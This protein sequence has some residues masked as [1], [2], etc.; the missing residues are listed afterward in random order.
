MVKKIPCFRQVVSWKVLVPCIL[1][2]CTTTC[3]NSLDA[4]CAGG[5]TPTDIST[6]LADAEA[7]HDAAKA[8]L[9]AHKFVAIEAM[10]SV[11]RSPAVNDRPAVQDD[12]NAFDASAAEADAALESPGFLRTSAADAEAALE[13][14]GIDGTS[15]ADAEAASKTD[16]LDTTPAAVA[17]AGPFVKYAADAASTAHNGPPQQSDNGF[18]SAEGAEVDPELRTYQDCAPLQ[19]ERISTEDTAHAPVKDAISSTHDKELPCKT[20]GRA[21]V[22]PSNM[23]NLG[24]VRGVQKQQQ[25]AKSEAY[26]AEDVGNTNGSPAPAGSVPTSLAQSQ[27]EATGGLPQDSSVSGAA[28]DKM[29]ELQLQRIKDSAVML[30]V[31]AEVLVTDLFD[32]RWPVLCCAVLCCAVLCCAVLCCAVLC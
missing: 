21:S 5:P 18:L 27:S 24:G 28:L 2:D 7:A 15:A 32:H 3:R 25:S 10:P 14:G 23:Q 17:E 31:P 20:H 6:A 16:S 9:H 1:V 4:C 11:Q 13:I 26:M 12:V 8:S 29:L 22:Q 19:G 30:P